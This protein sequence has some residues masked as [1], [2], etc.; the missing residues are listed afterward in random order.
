M[1]PRSQFLKICTE[2]ATYFILHP[3]QFP[4]PPQ[5]TA[6]F[7][8]FFKFH[9]IWNLLLGYVTR[10]KAANGLVQLIHAFVNFG[11][12]SEYKKHSW[13]QAEFSRGGNRE[14]TS[15]DNPAVKMGTRHFC[16]ENRLGKWLPYSCSVCYG[17]NDWSH[18]RSSHYKMGQPQ[19][20]E[21]RLTN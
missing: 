10:S 20:E 3:V 7:F 16:W 6:T 19:I 18:K 2:E 11:S 15:S 13:W 17:K 4:Q 14:Q 12:F 8:F 5:A 9:E 21:K 1:L